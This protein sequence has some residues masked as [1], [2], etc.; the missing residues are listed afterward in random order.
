MFDEI[1][2]D[3][4]TFKLFYKVSCGLCIMGATIGVATQY[5]GILLGK[6]MDIIIFYS[7][8]IIYYLNGCPPLKKRILYCSEAP[9][10]ASYSSLFF[11]LYNMAN[12]ISFTSFCISCNLLRYVFDLNCMYVVTLSGL[13]GTRY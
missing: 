2:I 12:L 10:L 11:S 13:L 8:S 4:W 5:F 3:N 7:I 1:N 9:K 6:I